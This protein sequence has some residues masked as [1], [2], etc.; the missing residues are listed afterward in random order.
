RLDQIQTELDH[1]LSGRPPD[2][3]L[4][5]RLAE[6]HSVFTLQRGP[7]DELI[8]GAR[9]DLSGRSVESEEDLVHYSNLVG[10]SIGAMM[11]PLLGLSADT[12]VQQQA[13][14]LGIGMQIT[15]I[16]R[17]VGEDLHT[18][19]RSYL[20][21][22]MLETFG[23]DPSSSD[24]RTTS[25]RLMMESLMSMA[26]GYF[27]SG[28]NGIEAL[29]FGMRPGI[30]AASLFYREILNEVRAN[31]YDNV[32]RRAYVP[33]RRKLLALVP[34]GYERRKQKLV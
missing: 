27:E 9:W 13:R 14:D 28:M 1:T 19:N 5:T 6:V 17:D 26:E 20:P 7:M 23:V 25:Y 11:L 4:W 32:S 24:T 18:L 33:N 16:L 31:D 2:Q 8:D 15:N 3:L 30:R 29:P 22:S 34:G 12:R 10:G 21:T